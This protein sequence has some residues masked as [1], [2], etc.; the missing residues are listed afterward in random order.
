[1]KTLAF[2]AREKLQHLKPG[3][4]GQASR[5]PGIS[6]SDLHSLVMEVTRRVKRS[7][8]SRETDT[9][10]EKKQTAPST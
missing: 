6:P 7:S 10:A 3:T 9:L 1:M 5:V 4:L 2:E 8:V